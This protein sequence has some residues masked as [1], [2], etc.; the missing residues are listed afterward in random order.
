MS[1]LIAVKLAESQFQVH[2]FVLGHPAR[3]TKSAAL[4]WCGKIP[5]AGWT[6]RSETRLGSNKGVGAILWHVS[7]NGSLT[8]EWE[9]G[10]QQPI[11]FMMSERSWSGIVSHYASCTGNLTF[12]L[13][14]CAWCEASFMDGLEAVA[15]AESHSL[16]SEWCPLV[17]AYHTSNL[18]LLNNH[19]EFKS[20]HCS[21]GAILFTCPIPDATYSIRCG[22]GGHCLGK[23]YSWVGQIRTLLGLI[24]PAGRRLDYTFHW[25]RSMTDWIWKFQAVL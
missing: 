3:T 2:W 13:L 8:P 6:Q 1:G 5:V 12:R 7:E 22:A 15:G 18:L 23:T 25:E 19:Q 16:G 24:W 9:A 4:L 17:G 10:P 21:F 11:L 14:Q 20:H